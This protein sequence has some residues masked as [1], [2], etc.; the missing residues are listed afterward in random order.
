MF[1]KVVVRR[2]YFCFSPKVINDFFFLFEIHRDVMNFEENYD[3][4]FFEL[5]TKVQ[6]VSLIN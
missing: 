6:T 4:V 3:S 2:T 1:H 5:T